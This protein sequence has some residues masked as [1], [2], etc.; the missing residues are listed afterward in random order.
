RTSFATFRQTAMQLFEA[1]N[2]RNRRKRKLFFCIA[3]MRLFSGVSGQL[4]S[5]SGSETKR[6]TCRPAQDYPKMKSNAIFMRALSSMNA[7]SRGV[8]PPVQVRFNVALK[9]TARTRHASCRGNLRLCRRL[10][11][12][13]PHDEARSWERAMNEGENN[14]HRKARILSC[15]HFAAAGR[16]GA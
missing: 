15:R 5:E 8:S 1:S 12:F 13:Y 10:R 7:T 16:A 4:P 14:E 3:R 11:A 9:L 2:N 6:S